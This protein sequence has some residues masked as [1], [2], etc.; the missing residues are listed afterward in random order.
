MLFDIF[1]KPREQR[2]LPFFTDIHCHVVPGVDDGSP[3]VDSSIVLLERM[4]DW[5]LTRIFASPHSTADRFENT[6]E[7]IAG[8]FDELC[9]AVKANGLPV[10]LHH[11]MEYRLDEF[12]INRLDADDIVT[13]PG[14]FLLIENSFVNEAWG[15]DGIVRDLINSGYRPVMAHPERYPFYMNQRNRYHELQEMGIYFQINL[16]SLSGYYGKNERETALYLLRHNLVQFI[17]T[18]IHRPSHLD[19]VGRYLSSRQYIN[20]CKLFDRLQNDSL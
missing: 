6:R 15:L 9:R 13:L 14:N 16:L 19:S 4:A 1:R 17:G 20:D 11:H 3:D 8:P 2:K 5:G 12:F 10:E 18:D 7:T